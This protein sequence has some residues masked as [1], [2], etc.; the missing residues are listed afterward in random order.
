MILCGRK[1]RP[2]AIEREKLGL[3]V[4]N[5]RMI[6]RLFGRFHLSPEFFAL[7]TL[8]PGCEARKAIREGPLDCLL[9]V[10]F[11]EIC[12]QQLCE[13]P[14]YLRFYGGERCRAT[15]R[16]RPDDCILK[17]PAKRA[18]FQLL[19][20]YA[21]SHT[22]GRARMVERQVDKLPL[23]RRQPSGLQRQRYGVPFAAS[24]LAV[25]FADDG[26]IGE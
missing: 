1:R 25:E 15:A 11:R 21:R 24:H 20:P 17:D 2:V 3:Q 4:R 19:R 9:P 7:F 14:L 22:I 23:D 10:V 18:I 8:A 6:T 16:L 5:R 13:Y 26:V 12:C